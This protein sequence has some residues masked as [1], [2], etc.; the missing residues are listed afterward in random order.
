[1]NTTSSNRPS[2]DFVRDFSSFR[3]QFVAERFLRAPHVCSND[4]RLPVVRAQCIT[5]RTQR[6]QK[7]DLARASLQLELTLDLQC[8]IEYVSL[9]SIYEPLAT[10]PFDSQVHAGPSE[11]KNLSVQH[12]QGNVKNSP[13]ISNGGRVE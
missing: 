9:I 12:I 13:A 8:L 6:A 5:I 2:V 3:W 1:M 7:E 4:V 10:S 11:V